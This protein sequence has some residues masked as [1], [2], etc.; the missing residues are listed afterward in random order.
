MLR[1]IRRLMLKIGSKPRIKNKS[2][3]MLK[4][5]AKLMS[6]W[7]KSKGKVPIPS[8]PTTAGD[9]RP[10]EDPTTQGYPKFPRVSESRPIRCNMERVPIE[11]HPYHWLV[12]GL[13]LSSC[14]SKVKDFKFNPNHPVTSEDL[15][16]DP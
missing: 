14:Y 5:R 2:R 6:L 9:K 15:K 4:R 1:L 12:C 3:L 10:T 7:D 11:G 8:D 16:N 13:G